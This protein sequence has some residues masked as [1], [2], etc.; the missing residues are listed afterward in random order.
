MGMF[1]PSILLQGGVRIQGQLRRSCFLSV[2]HFNLSVHSNNKKGWWAHDSS[3]MHRPG[4]KLPEMGALPKSSA[5][6]R[7]FPSKKAA[8]WNWRSPFRSRNR[9]NFPPLLWYLASFFGVTGPSTDGIQTWAIT[10]SHL[11]D[12][13]EIPRPTTWDGAKTS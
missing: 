6:F 2:Y 13:P 12:G 3:R 9:P 4:L 1:R 5:I 7:D 8:P 11:V 10:S